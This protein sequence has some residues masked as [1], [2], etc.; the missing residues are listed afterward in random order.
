VRAT[1]I[2]SH[3]V[4]KATTLKEGPHPLSA[5]QYNTKINPPKKKKKTLGAEVKVAVRVSFWAAH[6]KGVVL[7]LHCQG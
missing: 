7:F 1:N 4:A 5:M 6:K 3:L 2:S